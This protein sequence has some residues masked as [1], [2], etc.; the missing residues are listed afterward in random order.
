MCLSSLAEAAVSDL[1]LSLVYTLWLYQHGLGALEAFRVAG[2]G[3]LLHFA[4]HGFSFEVSSTVSEI[5][6]LSRSHFS[7]FLGVFGTSVMRKGLPQEATDRAYPAPGRR[8]SRG[9]SD[10]P[11]GPQRKQNC[12]CCTCTCTCTQAHTRARAHMHP[13]TLPL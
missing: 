2:P 5:C 10:Q 13:K 1:I 4:K 12:D 6:L 7:S 11:R 9:S 8:P 3:A